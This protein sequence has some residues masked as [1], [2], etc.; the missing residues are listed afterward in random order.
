M[1]CFFQT[2]LFRGA[3]SRFFRKKIERYGIKKEYYFESFQAEYG[4]DI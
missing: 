2:L 1:F 3:F 4:L